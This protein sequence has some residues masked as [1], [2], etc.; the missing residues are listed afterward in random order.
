MHVQIAHYRRHGTLI[1]R[2]QG[3][4]FPCAL[5]YP[6][7]ACIRVMASPYSL[8]EKLIDYSLYL[9]TGRDLLPPGKVRYY[10]FSGVLLGQL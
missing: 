9:V 10:T 4:Y 3:V 1:P 7:R 5:S 8:N 6:Y 2:P